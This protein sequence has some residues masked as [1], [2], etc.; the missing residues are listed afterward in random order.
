MTVNS[1]RVLS[2]LLTAALSVAA[3]SRAEALTYGGSATGAAVTVPATGTTIRAATG[4]VPI[5]GG[6]ADAALLV[7][8]I[9]GS[10]T[11]GVASLTVGVLR[12]AIVGLDATRAEASMGGVTLTVS[13]NQFTA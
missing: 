1:T 3:V 10:A 9:P 8:D 6:G 11:G 2:A 4:T 5:S 7:G 13:G 12:S